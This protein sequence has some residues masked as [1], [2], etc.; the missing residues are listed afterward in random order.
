MAVSARGVSAYRRCGVDGEKEAK[1][2]GQVPSKGISQFVHFPLDFE[3]YRHE[4][5]LSL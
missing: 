2:T 1:H 3:P 5:L 4:D